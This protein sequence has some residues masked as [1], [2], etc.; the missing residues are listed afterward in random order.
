MLQAH[1]VRST[2]PLWLSPASAALDRPVGISKLDAGHAL[3]LG[4]R[5]CV[6]GFP[7]LGQV[8]IVACRRLAS[9]PRRQ[10]LRFGAFVLL[11]A[12]LSLFLW[13]PRHLPWKGNCICPDIASV[14]LRSAQSSPRR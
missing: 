4:H 14:G 6:H 5:I 7:L 13:R 11:R 10:W 2:S 12:L 3:E 8:V 1:E 9:L